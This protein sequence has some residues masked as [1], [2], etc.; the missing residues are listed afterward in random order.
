MTGD[1]NE[2]GGGGSV[3]WKKFLVPRALEE[4]KSSGCAPRSARD[5]T[6][7][8]ALEAVHKLTRAAR[9]TLQAL[10]ERQKRPRGDTKAKEILARWCR[11]RAVDLE[12]TTAS[13][14][15]LLQQKIDGRGDPK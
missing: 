13:A 3:L 2:R 15:A 4:L 9:Q 11:Q 6:P 10:M 1:W 12:S 5:V 14:I 8:A 7:K